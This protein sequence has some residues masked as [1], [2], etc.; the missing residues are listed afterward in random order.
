MSGCWVDGVWVCVEGMWVGE[1]GELYWDESS[2]GGRDESRRGSSERGQ[3]GVRERGD[4][5]RVS[6]REWEKVH[7]S[8]DMRGRERMRS[9]GILG[10]Q[11]GVTNARGREDE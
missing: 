11:T 5:W 6:C 2:E 7:D 3:V 10:T 9:T 1:G 4:E 8:A